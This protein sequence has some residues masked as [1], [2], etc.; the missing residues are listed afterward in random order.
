MG[1]SG[2]FVGSDG[3]LREPAKLVGWLVAAV[4]VVAAG[5]LE[6][7]NEVGVLLPASWQDEVRAVVAAVTVV[8]LVAS[9]VQALLTRNGRLGRL[10]VG[11]SEFEG[12]FS[13]F[14]VREAGRPSPEEVGPGGVG[15]L[16]VT[17]EAGSSDLVALILGFLLVVVVLVLV[18]RI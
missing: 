4:L 9:R 1:V 15:P 5:L 13:P 12:V 3:W 7:A 17:P 18:G 10:S 14:T 8:T 6:L 2:G 16:A 11:G